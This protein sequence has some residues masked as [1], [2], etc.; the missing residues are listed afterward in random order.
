MRKITLLFAVLLM[1]AVSYAQRPYGNI[2]DVEQHPY[3]KQR[4]VKDAGNLKLPQKDFTPKRA[5]RDVVDGQE[6]IF[7]QP[8]GELMLMRRSG[9]DYLPV[10]GSPAPADYTEKGTYV[11]KGTD[12]CYYFKNIVTN[13]CN[14]GTWVKGT[15][16]DGIIE[17]ET[18]QISCQLWYYD[19]LY[20]YVLFALHEV[21]ATGT[22]WQGNEY[23]YTTYDIDWDMDKIM[24][25]IEDDGTITSLD[26]KVMVGA[27]QS[28]DLVWPGYGDIN[29]TFYPFDETPQALPENLQ[30]ES[31]VMSYSPY[32]S[33]VSQNQVQ[34]A[35]SG[36]KFYV[37][38]FSAHYP[39]MFVTLDIE[40]DKAV[41]KNNQFVG[42]D[43]QYSTLDYVKACSYWDEEDEWGWKTIFTEEKDQTEFAYDA[44]NKRFTNET[45]GFVLNA[46]KNSGISSHET[47][48][49]PSF[50]YFE[51]KPAVPANPEWMGLGAYN[52][53]W[54]YGWAQ[55]HIY[56]TDVDGSYIIPDKLFY[57]VYLDGELATIDT[58]FI[59]T[60]D[61]EPMTDVPYAYNCYD[62]VA[63]GDIHVLYYHK[64]GFNTI[65]V[66]AVY[67]GGG[68]ERVSEIVTFEDPN[69]IHQVA[70]G[71]KAESIAY[72]DLSGRRLTE[73]A[74]GLCIQVATLSDGTVKT[75]KVMVR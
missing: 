69:G 13:M 50:Y 29:S 55:F 66:Q 4:V 59:P 53:E 18:G 8:E 36:D 54:G 30:M 33:D 23:T 12:G 15:V 75:S 73:P 19:V 5:M 52:E 39:D 43:P 2:D 31:Y 10:Y 34:A 27:V 56:A 48:L 9:T 20:T 26:D 58:E 24:L 32:L 64:G 1:A 17:I 7:D 71:Q 28:D 51:E 25:K 49:Q 40:G 6:P 41:L 68:E 38:G 35:I 42:V 44:E 70:D 46:G 60:L 16:D 74:K 37:T 11:V 61:V 67:K 62:I 63:S 3:L 22:D 47:Y 72:F 65:G 45:E 21:E 14:G 57:R